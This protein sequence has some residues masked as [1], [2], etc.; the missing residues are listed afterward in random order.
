MAKVV[1]TYLIGKRIIFFL[2][3]YLIP[4]YEVGTEVPT[5]ERK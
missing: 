2:S 3:A 5:Q 1:G 4:R